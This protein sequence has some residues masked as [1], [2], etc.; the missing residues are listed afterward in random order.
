MILMIL[1]VNLLI[2]SE[3]IKKTCQVKKITKE[4]KVLEPKQLPQEL[5][6][7]KAKLEEN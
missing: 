6:K 3:E 2:K 1:D 4:T 5:Y 7:N